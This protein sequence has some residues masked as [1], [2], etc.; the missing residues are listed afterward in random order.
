MFECELCWCILLSG[1]DG[2]N[3]DILK[4]FRLTGRLEGGSISY[5]LQ[6]YNRL[7]HSAGKCFVSVCACSAAC[8]IGRSFI[9]APMWT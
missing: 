4:L 8:L 1:N 7:G 3:I 6:Q 9:F 5:D 2:C